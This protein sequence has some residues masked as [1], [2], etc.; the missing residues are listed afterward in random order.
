MAVRRPAHLGNAPLFPAGPPVWPRTDPAIQQAL[1]RSWQTGDW[2]RYHGAATQT[3]TTLMQQLLQVEHV[4]LCASGTAAVELALRALHLP[5]QSEV[6]LSAYDF[7]GNFKNVLTVGARPVL[8]D[9]API[10]GTIDVAQLD[11]AMTAQTKAVL[12]SH[13]HG[14]LADMPAITEWA[15][16]H[17][18]F[19]IEDACQVPGATVAGRPAGTWGDIGVWSFGGSKLLTAGRG[20]AVF[21][22]YATFAQRVRLYTQRGN[23]AYPLSELQAAVLVPQLLQLEQDTLTRDIAANL[24]RAALQRCA[25]FTPWETTLPESRA[26]YYKLGCWY[27]AAE[28]GGLT[29]GHVV[30]ALQAEG[31]AIDAGFRALHRS[32]AAARYRAAG[33]LPVASRADSAVLVLHHPWLLSLTD[34]DA[35]RLTEA[36]ESIRYHAEELSRQA[37]CP[38]SE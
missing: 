25:G 11:L 12:V 6:I 21:T 14:G 17:Q 20:G 2:G 5:A 32:H 3:C 15:R 9:Q 24:V 4:Q 34:A 33:T 28:F 26:A 23:D 37:V 19:V 18:V 10:T 27:D 36:I 13:L 8:V 1:H 7:Q 16:A 29:R 22:N 38:A 31:I 35:T 30:A